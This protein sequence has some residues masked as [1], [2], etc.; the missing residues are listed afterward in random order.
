M[1]ETRNL[2]TVRPALTIHEVAA[3]LGIARSTVYTIPWLIKRAF[4][5]VGRRGMRWD[6][7]DIELY[8]ELRST[9]NVRAAS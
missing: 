4:I 5:P 3:M 9:R 8:K 7:S 2:E 6:A 1:A